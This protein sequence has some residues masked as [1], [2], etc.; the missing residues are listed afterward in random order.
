MYLS[1]LKLCWNRARIVRGPTNI[2]ELDTSDTCHMSVGVW[3]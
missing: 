2:F 1:F 3:T